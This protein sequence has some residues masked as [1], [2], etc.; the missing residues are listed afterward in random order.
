[1]FVSVSVSV[2]LC[3]SVY[4]C[5]CGRGRG[6]AVCAVWAVTMDVLYVVKCCSAVNCELCL[7]DSV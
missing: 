6:L 3:A 2:Y 1:M 4:L 7:V 5:L